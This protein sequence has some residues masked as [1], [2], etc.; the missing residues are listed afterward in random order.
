MDTPFGAL[1]VCPGEPVGG[2]PVGAT[3]TGRAPHSGRFAL[4]YLLVRGS[5]SSNCQLKLFEG[6]ADLFPHR[7]QQ[8]SKYKSDVD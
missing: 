3:G 2:T 7:E 6:V 1:W 5:A 8:A 4:R